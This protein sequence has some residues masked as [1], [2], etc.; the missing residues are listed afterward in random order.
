MP[1][2]QIC[3]PL[4][5]VIVAAFLGAFAL[6]AVVSAQTVGSTAGSLGSPIVST[7]NLPAGNGIASGAV[8]N[9]VNVGQPIVQTGSSGPSKVGIDVLSGQ[10]SHNGSAA[11]ISVLN[12]DRLLGVSTG[13]VGSNGVNVM[14][15]T[16]KP[17]LSG[18]GNVGK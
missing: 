9:G 10:P 1:T 16:K 2:A 7:G 14:N 12:S 6:P 18:V 4:S 13:P 11:S 5:A 17:V 3:K 15:P 8:G